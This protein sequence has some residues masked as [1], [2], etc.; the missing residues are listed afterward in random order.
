MIT[1]AALGIGRALSVRL[2]GMGMS[3][4]MADLAGENLDAAVESA[5]RV[6]P[7]GRD[8]VLKVATDV[9][10]PDQIE[11]LRTATSEAFGRVDLL[12]NNAVTRAGRGFDADMEA[13]RHAI[14]VN[15]WGPI[16]GTRA[17]LSLLLASPGPGAVVN[18]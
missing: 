12:V 11:R 5:R 17:F 4:V 14:E 13:W 15:L 9:S 6:A 8:A 18:V 2:A 16:G 7:A 3:V 1:G 10:V